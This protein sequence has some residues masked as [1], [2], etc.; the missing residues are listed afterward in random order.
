MNFRKQVVATR[1]CDWH[2]HSGKYVQLFYVRMLLHECRKAVSV[3]H[4]E[5][6]KVATLTKEIGIWGLV[7]E[8][9]LI[10]GEPLVYRC[11]Q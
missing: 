9:D 11:G 2:R 3:G 6:F 4:S 10:N 1:D 8:Q 5:F 7:G